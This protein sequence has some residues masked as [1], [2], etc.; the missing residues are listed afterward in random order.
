MDIN[1]TSTETRC[2][3]YESEITQ[4]P[5]PGS[6]TSQADAN[7]AFTARATTEENLAETTET[8]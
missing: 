1:N 2:L 5:D 7:T 8:E 3:A 4:N 6:N